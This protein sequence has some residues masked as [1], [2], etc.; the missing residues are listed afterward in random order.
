MEILKVLPV[1][2][3]SIALNRLLQED[4]EEEVVRYLKIVTEVAKKLGKTISF[5][6]INDEASDA[7]AVECGGEYVEGDLY[8]PPLAVDEIR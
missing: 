7:V 8:G 6:G 4:E 5:S 2:Q 3:I 1:S